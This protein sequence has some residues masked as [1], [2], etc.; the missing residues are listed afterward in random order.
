MRNETFGESLTSIML[1]KGIDNKRLATDLGVTQA[2]ISNWKANRTG[3]ELTRLISLCNYFEC[4]LEY[5]VGKTDTNTKP[6]KKT[7]ENFGKQLRKV[8]RSKGVS[9]YTLQNE[10]RYTGAYF[11]DWDKGTQPK[12]STLIELANYLQCSL[13]ELVGLE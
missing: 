13:D 1:E 11:Y 3:I 2:S 9:T 8:M 5:L 10:T 7:I 4:S 12:L 6:I